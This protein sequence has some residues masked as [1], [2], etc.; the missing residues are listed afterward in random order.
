MLKRDEQGNL[1]LRDGK[2]SCWEGG[3]REPAIVHW[4]GQITAA[5]ETK[6]LASTMDI[7]VTMLTIAEAELPDVLLDGID[8]SPVLFSDTGKGHDCIMFYHE[9][10]AANASGEL[11]AVRCGD[12]KV[13]WATH[14]SRPQPYPDGKQDPP[15]IFNL[16]L[17]YSESSPLNST[18]AEYQQVLANITAAKEAH[19]STITPVPDQNGMG[20]EPQYALCADPDSKSK[21]PQYMNCTISPDNWLPS[22]ICHTP[23]C[24]Q[25][26]PTFR[27]HCENKT[28]IEA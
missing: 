2:G 11:F 13:Y 12:Y 7:F 22:D 28:T 21:Y 4:P 9:A 5:R 3:F 14:S 15:L 19:L 8:L 26:N 1:P 16:E 24:L 17:D 23:A 25:A 10:A 27:S 6:E 18:T 20:S